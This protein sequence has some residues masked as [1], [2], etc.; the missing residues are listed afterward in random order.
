M[1]RR[2]TVLQVEARDSI[3]ELLEELNRAASDIAARDMRARS[4]SSMRFREWESGS[5][6]C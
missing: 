4:T 2:R 3:M 6:F 1:V 5:M